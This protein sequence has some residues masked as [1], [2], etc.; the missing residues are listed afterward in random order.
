VR[1]ALPLVA[2]V[3]LATTPAAAQPA[4]DEP[5]AFTLPAPTDLRDAPDG[6][7]IATLPAGTVLLNLGCAATGTQDWCR[8]QPVSTGTPGVVRAADL[9]PAMGRDGVVARGPDPTPARARDG[10]ADLFGVL[11]CV[12]APSTDAQGC[13]FRTAVDPGGWATLV[14][15]MPDGRSRS[16]SFA[17][18][19]P[20]V[21]GPASGGTSGGPAPVFS[22]AVRDGLLVLRIG[23]DTVVVPAAAIGG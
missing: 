12:T 21:P 9:A 15:A 13:M 3:L 7:R 20:V 18:E 4:P 19:R 16:L 10:A 11:P 22:A 17:L 8:V 6:N 2:A 23:P 5:R 1:G 14:V